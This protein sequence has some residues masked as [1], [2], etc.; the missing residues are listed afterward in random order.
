MARIVKL[1][2][3]ESYNRKY[4]EYIFNEPTVIEDN[5]EAEYLLSIGKFQEVFYQEVADEIEEEKKT[6]EELDAIDGPP[7][8]IPEVPPAEVSEEISEETNPSVGAMTSADLGLEVLKKNELK[9][10]K[11]ALDADDLN[12]KHIL[13]KRNGA[14]GDTLFVAS[15]ANA[16]KEKFPAAQIDIAVREDLLE[17]AGSFECFGKILTHNQA[18][19]FNN[20]RIYDYVI[21]FD[22]VLED[23][24]V[25]DEDYFKLHFGMLGGGWTAPDRFNP[26]KMQNTAIEN[27]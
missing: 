8:P 26:I 18:A 14:I 19:Q 22:G 6:I 17:F 11:N 23:R 4:I 25:D 13:L 5:N 10:P 16:I 9:Q 27:L 1:V 15:V 12:D 3:G 24:P 20:L 7:R 2:R 21:P